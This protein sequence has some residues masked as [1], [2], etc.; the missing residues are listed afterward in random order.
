[1]DNGIHMIDL[2]RWFLGG[3]VK[4]V[5]GYATNHVWKQAGCEDNGFMLMQNE[6]SQVALVHSSWSEWRGWA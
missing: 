5:T 1:M 2:A 3:D 6:K 4:A